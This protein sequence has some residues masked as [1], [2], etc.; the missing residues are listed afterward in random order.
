MIAAV[1]LV[2][3]VAATAAT[4]EGGSPAQLAQ[5]GWSC[6]LPPAFNPN[7][8]CAPPGQLEGVVAGKAAAATFLAFRT[9][10]LTLRERALPRH[11]EAHPGRPLPRSAMS[12]RPAELPVQLALPAV[13]LGLLHLPHLRQS[14]V[15]SDSNVVCVCKVSPQAGMGRGF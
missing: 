8:H 7:V 12:D 2:A 1:L 5:A 15:T 6:F 9:E 13:R 3:T 14:V 4:A 10:D 11:G